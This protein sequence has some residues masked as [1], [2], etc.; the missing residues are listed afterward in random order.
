MSN[1]E[2]IM[3]DNAARELIEQKYAEPEETAMD[4]A[5]HD[6]HMSIDELRYHHDGD[7]KFH[8]EL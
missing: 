1:E 2:L 7:T 5:L 4:R 6:L 3:L 8:D